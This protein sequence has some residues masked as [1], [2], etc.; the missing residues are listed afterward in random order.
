MPEDAKPAHDLLND[1][2]RRMGVGSVDIE[3]ISRTEGE[4]LE[5]SGPHL[6]MLIGR[7]GS[8]DVVIEADTVSRRHARLTFRDGGWTVQDLESTNGTRLNGNPVGRCRLRAGD[9][10]VLADQLLRID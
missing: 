9:E 1:I 5:V 10:L 2:L 4:Y 7:H 3:Y 8:C 6:G